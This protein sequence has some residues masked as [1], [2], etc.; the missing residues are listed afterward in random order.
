[1]MC[2]ARVELFFR[3]EDEKDGNR[4]EGTH[5]FAKA[6]AVKTVVAKAYMN[7]PVELDGFTASG[8]A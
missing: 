5:A 6:V 7:G 4:K 2:N 1:M 8:A 3:Q